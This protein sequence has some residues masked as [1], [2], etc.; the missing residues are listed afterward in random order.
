MTKDVLRVKFKTTINPSNEN[1][2]W[3]EMTQ[4]KPKEELLWQFTFFPLPI[5]VSLPNTKIVSYS[6]EW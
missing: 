4:N 5:V 2:N 1:A 3:L 6:L